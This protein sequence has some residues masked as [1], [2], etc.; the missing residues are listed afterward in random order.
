[1]K[2]L[3]LAL[4]LVSTP[5]W[6]KAPAPSASKSCP[7]DVGKSSKAMIEFFTGFLDFYSRPEATSRDLREARTTRAEILSEKVKLGYTQLDAG[8]KVEARETF[9]Y[10]WSWNGPA[11]FEPA[12]QAR[13][14]LNAMNSKL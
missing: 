10:V 13:E 4:A 11:Y 8:C 6:G 9:E 14:A 1:M 7:A 2:K 5:A 3:L 12:R